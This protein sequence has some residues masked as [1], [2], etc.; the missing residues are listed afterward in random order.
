M[1][2]AG[3]IV[4]GIAAQWIAWRLRVPAI[5]LLLAVGF[6]AGQLFDVQ[7]QF[8]PEVFSAIV[9]LSVAIV[10][11]DGGLSLR[12]SELATTSTVVVRLVTVGCAITWGLAACLA[13]LCVFQ[14]WAMSALAGAV[15]T[16]TG[17][18]VIIP[19]LRQIRPRKPVGSIARW[20]GI[21]IDPIG[22]LLAVLVFDFV[23]ASG[24]EQAVWAV[25][26]SVLKTVVVAVLMGA[27][28]GI[29]LVE[30]MRRHLIP[31]YLHSP[32]LLATVL[33]SF[34]LSNAFQSESG[35]A[36][37]TVMGIVMAN[38]KKVNVE[39][40]VE[41]KENLG[42]LLISLLFIL[43]SSR[44]EFSSLWGLG[45]SGVLFV[46]G[47]IVIVRPLAILASTIGTELSRPGR[48]F[49]AL[50]APRGIVAAAVASVFALEVS[51]MHGHGAVDLAVVADAERLVPLTFMVIVGT[52]LFYSLTAGRMA[53]RMGLAESDPQGVVFAGGNALVRNLAL[54]IQ[55]EGFPV[56]IVD[57]NFDHIRSARMAGLTVCHASIVSE[58]VRDTLDMG[59]LGRLIAMTSNDQI[60]TLASIEFVHLFSRANV[61]RLVPDK[62]N[63]ARE[64]SVGSERVGQRAFSP[65][66]SSR[67]LQARMDAGYVV[68]ATRLSEEHPFTAFRQRYGDDC[69][70]CG[71]ID[72]HR[73]L[74]IITEDAK[75]TPGSVGTVIAIVGPNSQASGKPSDSPPTVNLGEESRIYNQESA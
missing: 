20:E 22:A 34:V 1:F 46:V 68:K 30:A 47:L 15:F 57:T 51:H 50:M 2:L 11:F 31:D 10:L 4:L 25:L 71:W 27:A 44:L 52:V 17:P 64:R 66:L 16:V 60:N 49:L 23:A 69:I 12:L 29:S 8:K 40:L 37:V 70:L 35:L 32:V 38:Q 39:H 21:V 45:I 65:A 3:V 55:A 58:Y 36:A 54:A 13:R 14:T 59:G 24:T 26:L 75:V 63:K 6:T 18:T 53:L 56:L 73:R 61:F 74:K 43:M 33:G 62:T 9:S 42:I 72:G 41:F 19:L 5:L 67:E 48:W 28:A 7:S